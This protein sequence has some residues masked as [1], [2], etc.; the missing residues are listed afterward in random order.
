[1]RYGNDT[2]VAAALDALG[3]AYTLT[4]ADA[5]VG[6]S[7]AVTVRGSAVLLVDA[8]FDFD[9]TGSGVG[10]CVGTLVVDGAAQPK[11]CH[12][13]PA[14]TGRGSATQVYVLT[15][16]AGDH[17]LK[18]QARKTINA[19]AAQAKLHTSLRVVTVTA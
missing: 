8:V 9:V 6:V 12:F 16:G 7:V 10:I 3:V 4:D 5:D 14:T 11:V 18:L 1:M 19:G 15:V 2:K 17:T 13:S